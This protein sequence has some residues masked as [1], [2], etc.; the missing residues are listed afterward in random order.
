MQEILAEVPAGRRG[1]DVGCDHGFLGCAMLARGLCRKVVF[2][3]VSAAGLEKARRLVAALGLEARA[4]FVCGPGL[5]HAEGADVAVVAGLGGREIAGVVLA[6]PQAAQTF[7]LQ[8]M[9]NGPELRAALVA[10]GFRILCDRKIADGGRFYDLLR[11]ERGEDTLSER[12]LRYGRT[13]LARGGAAFVGCLQSRRNVLAAA[14]SDERTGR[15]AAGRLAG[16]LAEVEELLDSLA[17]R[18]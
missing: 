17:K 10:G 13:N 12:E 8:P 1:C 4:Q 16:E 11:A 18:A 2:S 3:D 7:V 14:L 9:K 5:L 6:R 15:A